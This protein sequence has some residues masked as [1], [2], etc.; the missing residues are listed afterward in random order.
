MAKVAVVDDVTAEDEAATEYPL[1]FSRDAASSQPLR[2][3][4]D[5]VDSRPTKPIC[6]PDAVSNDVA[7]V[8]LVIV[9]VDLLCANA[10]TE[11]VANG[12]IF[13]RI[14]VDDAIPLVEVDGTISGFVAWPID[15]SDVSMGSRTLRELLWRGGCSSVLVDDRLEASFLWSTPWE[16]LWRGG[17]SSV[18]VDDRFEF[19]FLWSTLCSAPGSKLASLNLFFIA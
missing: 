2:H 19:P 4:R 5:L 12:G 7:V 18:L 16:V 10:G 1:L 15:D 11:D 3:E 9:I 13:G 17:C 14:L 8:V 6:V